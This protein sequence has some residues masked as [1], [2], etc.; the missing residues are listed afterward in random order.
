MS[1]KYASGKY[2]HEFCDVCS[3]RFP[4]GTLK[5]VYEKDTP[6]GIKACPECWDPSHPQLRLGDVPVCDPEALRDPRP[7]DSLAA[8]REIV[9]TP[10]QAALASMLGIS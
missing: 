2:A 1:E 10:E 9:T 4:Y 8:S 6:T 5:E 7:D 3:W